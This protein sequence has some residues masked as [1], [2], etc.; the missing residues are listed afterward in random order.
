MKS[1]HTQQADLVAL[2]LCWPVQAVYC[3]QA[4]KTWDTL[5][6]R[7]SDLCLCGTTHSGVSC[8]IK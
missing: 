5:T 7:Q 2:H 8:H 3:D 6:G 4:N 1:T